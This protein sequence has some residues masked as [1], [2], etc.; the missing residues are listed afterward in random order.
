MIENE[1]EWVKVIQQIESNSAAV[2]QEDQVYYMQATPLTQ[3]EVLSIESNI[4]KQLVNEIDTNTNG[5][6]NRQI[7]KQLDRLI[8]AF[9]AF[10]IQKKLVGF[11]REMQD[12]YNATIIVFI[13]LSN[14]STNQSTNYTST[15]PNNQQTNN[16]TNY[17]SNYQSN[18]SSN[19]PSNYSNNEQS[20]YLSNKEIELIELQF[21]SN[22]LTNRISVY[23]LDNYLMDREKMKQECMV[24]FW[25]NEVS[26]YD[27]NDYME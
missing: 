6:I 22:L 14:Y 26:L 12:N 15:F 5:D 27:S 1:S 16:P 13:N 18:Y 7:S 25:L 9:A 4:Q 10:D 11:Y 3:P 17:T 20:I 8:G 2:K 24:Q 19:F 21:E 23:Q